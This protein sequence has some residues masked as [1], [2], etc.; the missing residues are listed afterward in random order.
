[1][2]RCSLDA[3]LIRD[4]CNRTP[5]TERSNPL[6]RLGF[7]TCLCPLPRLLLLLLLLMPLLPLPLVMRNVT[8]PCRRSV[9]DDVLGL[10]T[11]ECDEQLA[12]NV[13]RRMR[14]TACSTV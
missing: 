8:P 12:M 1:M 2:L 14:N 6:R 5:T 3:V 10:S 11:G 4:K 7:G 13:A 9:C